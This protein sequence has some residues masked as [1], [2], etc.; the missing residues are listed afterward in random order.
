MR[1][2]LSGLAGVV[3]VADEHL[4]PVWESSE[5]AVEVAGDAVL[6][7]VGHA[8]RGLGRVVA[9]VVAEQHDLGAVVPAAQQPWLVVIVE[10]AP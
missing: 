3:V 8:V 6:A 9:L 1:G 2:E 7:C 5:A 10:R 4:D